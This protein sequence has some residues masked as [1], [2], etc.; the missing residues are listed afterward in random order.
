MAKSQYKSTM[1]K[2]QDN[3]ALPGR[4][5]PIIASTGY[6]NALKAQENECKSDLMMMIEAFVEDIYKVLKEMQKNTNR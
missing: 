2:T 5:Y 4:S 6:P 1:N 3:L